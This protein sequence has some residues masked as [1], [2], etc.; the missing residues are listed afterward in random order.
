MNRG[1]ASFARTRDYSP[2]SLILPDVTWQTLLHRR[3]ATA[4]LLAAASSC[5]GD[6]PTDPKTTI[7]RVVVTSPKPALVIGKR[8][9]LVAAAYDATGAVIAT[10]FEWGSTNTSIVSVTPAGVIEAVADG[11]AGITATA[12]GVVGAVSIFTRPTGVASATITGPATAMD[13]G[14]TFQSVLVARDFDGDAIV[15]TPT[16]FLWA[17]SDTSVTSVSATGLISARKP[18]F[19]MIR[20]EQLGLVQTVTTVN[21][22]V[23]TPI[24]A[25]IAV[26]L[27][28]GATSLLN[29]DSTQAAAIVRDSAARVIAGV[30]PTWTSSDPTIASV[31]G[32]G[33]VTAL[34]PGGPIAIIGSLF[35]GQ[36][37]AFAQLTVVPR[38]VASITLTPTVATLIQDSLVTLAPTIRDDRGT[39]VTGRVV[40]WST[41]AT[42]VATVSASGVVSAIGAGITTLTA[43]LDGVRATATIVVLPRVA[44]ITVTPG[45]KMLG[46]GLSET[47][48]ATLRDANGAVIVGR[49]VEWKAIGAPLV[50]SVYPSGIVSAVRTGTVTISASREGR[51]GNAVLTS[52]ASIVLTSAAQNYRVG[53]AYKISAALADSTGASTPIIGG[54]VGGLGLATGNSQV[55]SV[56]PIDTTS[57]YLAMSPGTVE[58]QENLGLRASSLSITVDVNPRDICGKAVGSILLSGD[59][60]PIFLGNVSAPSDPLSIFNP[61]GVYGSTTGALSM[62]NPNGRYGAVYS[63]YSARNPYAANPPFMSKNSIASY[64]VTLRSNEIL[65]TT[66]QYL[67][68]CA[69]P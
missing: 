6:A 66:P 28:S 58:I 12:N 18:G 39:I 63:D 62:N 43:S 49:P 69:L 48:V 22:T 53:L 45:T 31:S 44:S 17:S 10:P 21:V 8:L 47:F 51:S 11:F 33:V 55:L 19:S 4:I 64:F 61:T 3:L 32:T 20:A 40:T 54:L 34:R 29:G 38:P 5:G 42:D 23:R 24:P 16:T 30:V 65:G 13:V 36:L 46:T 68:T 35:T 41:L 37:S 15:P 50:V 56:L 52:F 59:A 7:R 26:T 25:S 9:T 60:S 2:A 1:H 27:A 14:D 67:A 57:L